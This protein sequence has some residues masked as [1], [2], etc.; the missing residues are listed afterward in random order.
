VQSAVATAPNADSYCHRATSA[1]SEAQAQE[2]LDA[3]L[4]A[5]ESACPG[6]SRT[7]PSAWLPK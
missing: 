3:E 7:K 6:F 4:T 5:F 2:T 1:S